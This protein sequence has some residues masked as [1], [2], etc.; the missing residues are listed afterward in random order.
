MTVY[1]DDMFMAAQVGSLSAVWC[2]LFVGPFDPVDELHTFARRVGLRVSWFQGPPDH[3]WPMWHYDVTKTVRAKAVKAGAVQVEYLG[4]TGQIM[5]A[6]TD[7][8]R[9]AEVQAGVTYDRKSLVMPAQLREI[10]AP[11]FVQ[12]AA[13][14]GLTFVPDTRNVNG[15][16][17]QR[18]NAFDITASGCDA[19]GRLF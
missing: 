18:E 10:A 19:E 8:M 2:H 9:A 4:G 17:P 6:A 15:A 1:V 13:T 7:A 12:A 3:L 14:R 11:L 5:V 16:L